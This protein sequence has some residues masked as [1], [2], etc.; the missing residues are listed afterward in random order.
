M[1]ACGGRV[2]LANPKALVQFQWGMRLVR[3]SLW[4]KVKNNINDQTHGLWRTYVWY[5]THFAY[6]KAATLDDLARGF[7]VVPGA[8]QETIKAYNDA[9]ANK[10]PGPSTMSAV[11]DRRNECSH[12][13]TVTASG[14]IEVRKQVI[15]DLTAARPQE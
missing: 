7:G 13:S 5:L 3:R 6:K 1:S 14:E 8:M 9:L 15:E 2:Q 12:V 10:Q 11:Q 4:D